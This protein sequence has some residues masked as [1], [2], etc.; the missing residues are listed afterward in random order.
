MSLVSKNILYLSVSRVLALILLF[1]AYTQVYRYLG[2]FGTGQYQFVLSY[3]TLFSV[4]VDFGISQLLTKE[5][6]ENPSEAKKYFYNFLFIEFFL[7]LILYAV[8]IGISILAK[9]DPIVI[10]AV[11]VAGVG[12]ML[13]GLCFPFLTILSGFQDLKRVALINFVNTLINVAVLF[14]AIWAHKYIVFMATQQILFGISSLLIYNKFIRR[15]ITDLRYGEWRDF[16]STGFIKQILRKAVPFTLLVGFSTI[17]NRIDVVIVSKMLGF[18]ETGLYTAAYKFVDV[19]NFF[20]AVI[21]HSLYPMFAGE[22]AKKGAEAIRSFFERYVRLL[23]V[24]ALPLAV[25]AGIYSDEI[26]H[27]IAGP[28]FTKSV[29]VLAVLAWAV[30]VLFIYTPANALVISQL[31]RW[32]VI[33]TA[34]NVVLNIVGNIILIPVLGIIAPALMTVISESLQGL[35]YYWSIRKFI[36]K[37][38][39]ARYF[40]KPVLACLLMGGVL[41]IIKPLGVFVGAVVGVIVYLFVLWTVKFIDQEDRNLFNSLLGKFK[42]IYDKVNLVLNR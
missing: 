29:P 21:A 7:V 22:M 37:Y 39:V 24:L 23:I 13:N 10:K 14:L 18:A 38:R 40:L 31:T 28:E 33:F 42:P 20:P 12:M 3:V 19:M 5:T 26:M 6:A 27:I 2:P 25:G 35:G 1:I 41:W 9:F 36:F 17:Y 15:H 11:A 8:C 16:L 30:A 34:S 32:A 4:I